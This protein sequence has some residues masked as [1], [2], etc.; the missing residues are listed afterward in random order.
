[1]VL[2]VEM[3]FNIVGFSFEFEGSD[4]IGNRVVV[5]III[6]LIILVILGGIGICLY[7]GLNLRLKK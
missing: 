5:G 7:K 4:L 1:M 6:V 2:L 3:I